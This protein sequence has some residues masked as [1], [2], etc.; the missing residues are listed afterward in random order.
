MAGHS[1]WANI[2]HRKQTVDSKKSQHFHRLAKEIQRVLAFGN[3]PKTN[4][5]LRTVLAKAKE[6]NFPRK[7]IDK[8][9]A[10]KIND[11]ANKDAPLFW[12]GAQ[13]S[14]KVFLLLQ[15]HSNQQR[16]TVNE[17]QKLTTKLGLEVLPTSSVTYAFLEVISFT[18]TNLSEKQ[19]QSML[20]QFVVYDF[21]IDQEQTVLYFANTALINDFR[22]FLEKSQ[23][24]I[25]A[26][27]QTYL[28]KIKVKIEKDLQTKLNLC[29]EKILSTLDCGAIIDNIQE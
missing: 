9:L 19:L 3:N 16:A 10:G 11:D 13:F 22:S 6:I 12:V 15:M 17:L 21:I 23:I 28:P 5:Q 14:K 24:V 29:K 1:K 4:P 8:L 26:T 25:T 7:T 18:F 2:R 20:D 27:E